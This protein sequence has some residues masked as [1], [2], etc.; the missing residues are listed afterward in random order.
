MELT[1]IWEMI[2]MNEIFTRRSIRNYTQEVVEDTKIEKLLRAA[3]QAPSAGNQQAWEFIIVK[4]KDKLDKL[5]KMSLYATPV[6]KAPVAIV[7]LG[8]EDNMKYPELWEQD[9]GAATE[10]LLLEAVSEGLATVWLGVAPL[11]DRIKRIKKMFNLP[12]NIKPYAV[13]ALGYP[14]DGQG[15]KFVDR[16][17]ASKVHE[18]EF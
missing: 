7:V 8:N 13:I 5:S 16:Y 1:N 14:V 2:S 3:M 6:A 12:L 9:L 4:N 18:E 17:D 10:N 11:E 15:N